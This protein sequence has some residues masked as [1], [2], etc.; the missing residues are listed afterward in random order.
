MRFHRSARHLELFGNLC[1]VTTLH[2]QLD[3]L[4]FARTEPDGLLFHQFPL[5]W[6]RS[7]LEAYFQI[8]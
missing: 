7:A 8:S 6:N 2:Q 4:L 1:V 5:G 3:D